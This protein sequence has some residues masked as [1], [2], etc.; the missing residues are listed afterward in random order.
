MS[1]LQTHLQAIVNGLP[2]ALVAT[3]MGSDGIQ[4]ESYEATAL[5]TEEGL[6][7]SSLMVEFSSTMSQVHR[8]GELFAAG[9]L[10]ELLIRSERLT[11]LLRPLTSEYFVAVAMKPVGSPGKGRYLLRVHGAK[12]VDEIS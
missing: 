7:V 3:L 5:A 2:G 10:T 4:V 6:D 11:T 1:S 9:K 8:T 12:L